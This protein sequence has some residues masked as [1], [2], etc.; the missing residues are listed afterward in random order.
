MNSSFFPSQLFRFL[1]G[2]I[3]LSFLS[4]GQ[5]EERPNIIVF[6]A[7]D[8]G[9]G[10]L[11]CYGNSIIETPHLDALA[12]EGV[13]LTDCHSGGTVCSPSRASLLTGRTPYRTGFYTIA[14]PEGSHL[15]KQEITLAKLLKD[16]GYDTCFVGKWHLG[17]FSGQP[18]PGAHG[19]DHWFGTAVNAFDGPQD[20]GKFVLNGT[21]VE[22][23]G[24]W[25]CD[26]IVEEAISWMNNRPDQKKP[27]FLFICSHEP[28]TPVHPPEKYSKRYENKLIDLKESE[29]SYGQVH[30]P[31]DRA[32]D[33]NKKYYYGTVTQLDDA[34]GRL[35]TAVEKQGQEDN[36]LVIFTSDNGPETPVTVE[37][38]EN[39]WEDPIRDRC[40]GTPGP[41]RG[42][43]RYVFEGGHR[44]PGIVRWPGKVKAGTL[45]TQLVN[46][47]DW[48]PTAC[49]A[50]GV[51]VP[52]DRTIDGI[53]A[54]PAL[55]GED[56]Q[57]PIP[58]CWMFPVGY[59]SRKLASMSMRD[60]SSVLVGWFDSETTGKGNSAW[61]KAAKLDRFE[62]FDLSIDRTQNN[63]LNEIRPQQF[64]T[65][66]GKMEALWSDIQSDAPDWTKS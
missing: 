4:V 40:F 56:S 64:E 15:R 45:S 8:L 28:H 5:A 31:L 42:M 52:T 6:L 16:D 57:R 60:G 38:S 9:Y 61:V 37:E 23:T 12:K 32:I 55:R 21:P 7:D 10:D 36:S 46:G 58:A 17:K 53:D 41:W 43:K 44:V 35:M 63:P 2:S 25:Y 24:K 50:A 33:S 48:L 14:G 47:T 18:D 65:L 30:R 11:A 3:F 59:D 62:L 34:F 13:L 39:L 26:A 49:A 19:F 20:P 29:V 22:K 27:F 54:L 51:E 1:L 66:K